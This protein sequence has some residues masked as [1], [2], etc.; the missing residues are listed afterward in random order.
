MRSVQTLSLAGL[1]E[2][3]TPEDYEE[4]ALLP[5]L[6]ELHLDWTAAPWAEDPVLPGIRRLRLNK[7]TGNE[8]L[9]AV[10]ALFPGLRSVTFVLDSETTEVPEQVLEL[11]AGKHTV[12]E[13]HT[14]LQARV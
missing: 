4:A 13:T 10:S 2:Q 9:S 14:A 12:R 6:E 3:L 1:F 5:E 7:F 8:D 11:F